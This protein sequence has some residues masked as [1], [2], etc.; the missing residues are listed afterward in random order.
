MQDRTPTKP[1]VPSFKAVPR[2]YRHDGWTAERQRAFIDALAETGSVK[3][4]AKQI[5]M[6]K[7]GAYYLRRQAGAEGFRAAWLAALDHG[8]A[9][10]EDIAMDRALYGVEV[11]VY[12][13]GKI[14]GTRTWYND[15]L[16]MFMLRNRLPDRFGSDKGN[17]RPGGR[18][19]DALRASMEQEIREEIRMEQE[20]EAKSIRETLDIKLTEMRHRLQA[21]ADAEEAMEDRPTTR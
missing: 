2:K 4:A 21:R 7:E 20:E 15:R 13:Y 16:L 6:S 19:Y 3:A 18:L 12:S 1:L 14:I 10:I 8:V 5:N 17:L 11:P 9:R